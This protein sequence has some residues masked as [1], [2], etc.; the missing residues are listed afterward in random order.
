MKASHSFLTSRTS[1]RHC[2]GSLHPG[3]HKGIAW[4]P[5]IQDSTKALHGILTS[6]TS[7]RHTLRP[8]HP[9]HHKCS[10]CKPLSLIKTPRTPHKG[11]L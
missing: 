7:Q 2:M 11:R 3:H 10:T 5:Y 4:V 8:L 1:Q 6:R 9:R